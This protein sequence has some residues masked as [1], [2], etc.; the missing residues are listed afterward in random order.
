MTTEI[1][2]RLQFVAERDG[3]DAAEDWAEKALAA[4]VNAAAMKGRYSEQIEGLTKYLERHGRAVRY[5]TV[6]GVER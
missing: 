3:L 2:D 1:E 4:Y 6:R 5:V